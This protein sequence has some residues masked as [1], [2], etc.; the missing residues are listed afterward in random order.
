[1]YINIWNNNELQGLKENVTTIFM[2]YV[3]KIIRFENYY[4]W[5]LIIIIIV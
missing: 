4:Y 2:D 1:M 5:V 3:D